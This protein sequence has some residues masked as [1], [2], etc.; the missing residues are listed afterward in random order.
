METEKKV[1]NPFSQMIEYQG[2]MML[3]EQV[4]E[5]KRIAREWVA[6][7]PIAM[8]EDTYTELTGD[9]PVIDNPTPQETVQTE[10][11]VIDELIKKYDDMWTKEKQ[12]FLRGL[13][14][15]KGIKVRGFPCVASLE[16]VCKQNSIVY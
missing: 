12:M 8:V 5:L 7:A 2:R 13:L 14:K 4:L 15:E 9:V 6:P 3:V 10:E 16:L 11:Q 1:V